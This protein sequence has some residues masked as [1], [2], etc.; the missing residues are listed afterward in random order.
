VARDP[1]DG[2]LVHVRRHWA[3]GGRSGCW[4][5]CSLAF[6]DAIEQILSGNR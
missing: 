3:V 1:H 6:Y 2:P 5:R 4:W